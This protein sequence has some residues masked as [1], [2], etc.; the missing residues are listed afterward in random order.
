MSASEKA[1]VLTGGDY[2][3]EVH[4]NRF[5][6]GV[7]AIHTHAAAAARRATQSDGRAGDQAIRGHT[8]SASRA[9]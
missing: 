5:V 6:K 9:R 8:T 7:A 4:G 3:I 1:W 2:A